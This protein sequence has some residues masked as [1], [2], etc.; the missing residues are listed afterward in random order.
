MTIEKKML[1][2]N[3]GHL[4]KVVRE[5]ITLCNSK[6]SWKCKRPANHT[7][8]FGNQFLIVVMTSH[9]KMEETE[10]SQIERTRVA[11]VKSHRKT[12]NQYLPEPTD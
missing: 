12:T 8:T 11:V 6:K 2:E 9:K 10:W 7:Q 1:L 4:K 5:R 3:Y